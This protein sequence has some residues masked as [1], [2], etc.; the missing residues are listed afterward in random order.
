MKIHPNVVIAKMDLTAN[1]YDG[2]GVKGFPTLRWFPANNKKM[3]G[4]ECKAGR[5][6]VDLVKFV[7]ENISNG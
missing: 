1:E 5:E 7:E 4:M 6:I 3:P 2:L